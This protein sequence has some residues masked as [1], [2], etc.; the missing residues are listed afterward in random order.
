M[1]PASDTSNDGRVGSHSISAATCGQNATLEL[2]EEKTG[3]RYTDSA[4]ALPRPLNSTSHETRS[5]R[6]TRKGIMGG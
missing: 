5:T 6:H 2:L 3:M 4:R 1:F